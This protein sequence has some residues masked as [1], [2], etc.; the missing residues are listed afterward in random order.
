MDNDNDN[1]NDRKKEFLEELVSIMNRY[2]VEFE[3]VEE[4]RDYY[5]SYVE[6][7][8]INFDKG[9]YISMPGRYVD[10]DSIKKAIDEL[11]ERV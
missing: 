7:I 4:I 5:G 3:V 6:S 8:D 11:K 10:N 2:G 1:D 9:G